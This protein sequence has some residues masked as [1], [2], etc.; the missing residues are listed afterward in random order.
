MIK[1]LLVYFYTII[2][3]ST[4]CHLYFKEGVS[5]TSLERLR[6][7]LVSCHGKHK[8]IFPPSLWYTVNSCILYSL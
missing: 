5:R 2:D 6:Q 1:V 4:L 7:V 3:V 8:I